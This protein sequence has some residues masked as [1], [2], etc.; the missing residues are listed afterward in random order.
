[1]KVVGFLMQDHT[2]TDKKQDKVFSKLFEHQIKNVELHRVSTN[3]N[4]VDFTNK[5]QKL[6]NF[7]KDN[8]NQVCERE[9]IIST[10]WPEEEEL[11]VTDWA[12][13]R[14]MARVRGKLK[15]QNNPYE[16]VTVKTRGYKLIGA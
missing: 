16:V 15:K 2:T 4:G 8:I 9:S 1:M 3:I 6:F 7:L 11:G 5:E 14:L 13:D 12:V 10:V